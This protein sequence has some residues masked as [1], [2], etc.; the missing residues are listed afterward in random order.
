M[1]LIRSLSRS[2]LDATKPTG[3]AILVDPDEFLLAERYAVLRRTTE[4]VHA[5]ST[6]S[7]L[8][9]LQSHEEP[10]VAI[11]SSEIGTFQLSA[12]TEYARHRWP[13][14]RI[15]IVGE[16]FRYLEDHLY[17]E[18]VSSSASAAEILSAVEKCRGSRYLNN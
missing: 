15:L 8:Y 3:T 12:V 16:A 7:M 11:F 13:H 2:P 17:D 10:V 9:E 5:V 14:A 4:V 6:P 18:T 1:G